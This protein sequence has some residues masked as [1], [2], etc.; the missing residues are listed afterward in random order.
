MI[1]GLRLVIQWNIP[2]LQV[3]GDSQLVI[4]Q[5]NDDYENKDDKLMP[6]KQMEDFLKSKFVAISFCQISRIHNRQ[7]NAM[8]TITSMINKPQN[9]E[10]CEF[11]IKQLLILAFELSQFEFMCELVGPNSPQY[12]DIYN[13][14]HAQILPPNL[15]KNEHRAFIRQATRYIIFLDALTGKKLKLPYTRFMKVYVEVI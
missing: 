4:C 12:K 14:L 6:Y 2:H 11:L 3:F 10:C 1:I 8:A 7:A 15:S 5:V 9:V 13:Y